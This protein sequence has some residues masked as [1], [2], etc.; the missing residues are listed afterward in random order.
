MVVLL[1]S[2]LSAVLIVFF[3]QT[4]QLNTEN[5]SNYLSYDGVESRIAMLSSNSSFTPSNQTYTSTDGR[6]IAS[7]GIFTINLTLRNDYSSDNPPPST[8]TPVAPIDGTAYVSLEVHLLVYD[9]AHPSVN[10]SPSDFTPSSSDQ[11]GLVLASGETKT[12]QLILVTNQTR[13]TG[14][15]INIESL[16]DSIPS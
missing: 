16:T 5:N 6:H 8:G 4:P 7:G 14:Y 12:V 10:L 1:V 15:I 2:A 13:I 3:G 9:V 11:T